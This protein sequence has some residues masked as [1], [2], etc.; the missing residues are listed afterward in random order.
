MAEGAALEMRCAGNRTEGSNP[1][2]SV[3]AFCIVA[4]TSAVFRKVVSLSSPL[5]KGGLQGGLLRPARTSPDPSLVRRGEKNRTTFAETAI[6]A[7]APKP[8]R[9][10]APVFE[11]HREPGRRP[12]RPRGVLIMPNVDRV[13]GG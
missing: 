10:S 12:T 11:S 6:E 5:A 7:L 13:A 3:L 1:S 9:G 4:H 2:R 8:A